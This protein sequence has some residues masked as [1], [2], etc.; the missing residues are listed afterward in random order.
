MTITDLTEYIMF[1][2]IKSRAELDVR[3]NGKFEY[4]KNKC[5]DDVKDALRKGVKEG[6]GKTETELK[7]VSFRLQ[8]VFKEVRKIECK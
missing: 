4:R 5:F 8:D 7:M 2:I 6:R 3:I 1:G